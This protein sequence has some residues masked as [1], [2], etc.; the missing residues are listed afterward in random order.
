MKFNKDKV[1]FGRHE[2]FPL[3]YSWLTKGFLS[4]VKNPEIF[5]S[6]E[7]TVELGVGKNMVNSIRF[8][9]L[10]SQIVKY[11]NNKYQPTEIGSLIFDAERGFD[12]FLEDEATLWLI[13]WLISTNPEIATA[14]FWFFN[15]YH[16]PEFSIEGT[17][18][19]LMEFLHHKI[20]GKYASTTIKGDT[21]ILLRMYSR[22]RG[23]TRTSL[24]EA[25]DSPLSL[26][27]LITQAPGG[28]NYFSYPE[29]RVDLPLCVFGFAVLQLLDTLEKKDLPIGDL[30]Y[31]KTDFPSLGAV[32]RLTEN[33]LISKL[34][35]LGQ[36]Y[37]DIFAVRE[38]AGIHQVYVLKTTDP[39]TILKQ[40]YNSDDQLKNAA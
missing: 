1:S 20:K 24:E 33:S 14:W 30:M 38:T 22:S 4:I 35:Q 9:L 31:S 23:N 10:A 6:P 7:A 34:E 3:R 8:W 17:S 36:I 28:R 15:R 16:K 19:S 11:S 39:L 21:S 37:G 5:K 29:E 40:Y 13:H 18:E 2:T 26:L 32:F 25:L 12:P 27:G